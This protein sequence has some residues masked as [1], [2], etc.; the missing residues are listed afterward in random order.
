[1]VEVHNFNTQVKVWIKAKNI[2][3]Y[4][5]HV[6]LEYAAI[7][8]YQTVNYKFSPDFFDKDEDFDK[9]KDKISYIETLCRTKMAQLEKVE[10][11]LNLLC[12]EGWLIPNNTSS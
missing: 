10:Q 12:I 4:K 2:V 3:P 9:G 8:C 5:C 7:W 6:K 11:I 1:M